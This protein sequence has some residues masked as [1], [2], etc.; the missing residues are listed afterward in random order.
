[1]VD[2]DSYCTW[3]HKVMLPRMQYVPHVSIEGRTRINVYSAFGALAG[4]A[5]VLEA[6]GEVGFVSN[7]SFESCLLLQSK[8]SILYFY[9]NNIKFAL[10]HT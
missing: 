1:M 10:E 7:K 2:V 5:D 4:V 6:L 3:V 8:T 9:Y